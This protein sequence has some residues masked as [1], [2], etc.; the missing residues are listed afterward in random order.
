MIP[1]NVRWRE[2]DPCGLAAIG[3]KLLLVAACTS[4]EPRRSAENAAVVPETVHVERDTARLPA[5]ELARAS[6]TAGAIPQDSLTSRPR[7]I[8]VREVMRAYQ[9]LYPAALREA[10]IG[11]HTVLHLVL[12]EQGV[13]IHAAASHIGDRVQAPDGTLRP[14]ETTSGGEFEQAALE[15]ARAMR[16]T[17]GKCGDQ[18]VRTRVDAA[19]TWFPELRTIPSDTA[20]KPAQSGWPGYGSSRCPP[21]PGLEKLR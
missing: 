20:D 4:E 3:L 8:N 9:N 1:K 18:A 17:P 7:P 2:V 11:G 6:D 5:W 15:L 12:D 13:P 16:S 14:V 10:G 21:A 19:V